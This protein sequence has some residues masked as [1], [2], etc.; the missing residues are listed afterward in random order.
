MQ[1]FMNLA[2]M[3]GPVGLLQENTKTYK[4]INNANTSEIRNLLTSFSKRKVFLF[5]FDLLVE[6]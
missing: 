6:Y 2:H 1:D 5:V 4:Q 3:V